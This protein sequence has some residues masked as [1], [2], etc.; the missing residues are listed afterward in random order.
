MAFPTPGISGETRPWSLRAIGRSRPICAAAV[1]PASR[2]RVAGSWRYERLG[3]SD[4]V[5]LDEPELLNRL[6][7]EFLG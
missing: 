7:L 3:C 2:H 1:G 5:P 4:W 6:L